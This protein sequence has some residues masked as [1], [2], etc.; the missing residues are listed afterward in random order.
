M[1]C[2][3]IKLSLSLEAQPTYGKVGSN[4]EFKTIRL[5]G[6]NMIVEK[7]GVRVAWV[8]KP[9]AKKKWTGIQ[10]TTTSKR[11]KYFRLL[12]KSI[13]L[14]CLRRSPILFFDQK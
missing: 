5:W 11:N 13:R 12:F 10:N 3:K 1:T 6:T 8:N 14:S 9:I 7:E 2:C 4:S